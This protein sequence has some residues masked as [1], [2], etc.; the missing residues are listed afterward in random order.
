[1]AQNSTTRPPALWYPCSAS[2]TGDS[3]HGGRWG[4]SL[5]TVN[6]LRTIGDSHLIGGQLH[7]GEPLGTVTSGKPLGTVTFGFAGDAGIR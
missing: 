7:G 2:T 3:H 4:G 5:G 1:M 6:W